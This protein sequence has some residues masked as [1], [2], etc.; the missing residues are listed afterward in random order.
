MT[1]NAIDFVEKLYLGKNQ[2]ME[3]SLCWERFHSSRKPCHI[4]ENNVLLCDSNSSHRL[5]ETKLYD[6]L[7]VSPSASDSELKKAYRKLAMKWHPDKNDGNAEAE[8]KVS[9]TFTDNR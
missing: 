7:G 6:T 4:V 9:T 8:T 1:H 3:I 5:K 2:R